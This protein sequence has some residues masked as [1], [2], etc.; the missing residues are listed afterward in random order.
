VGDAFHIIG[1]GEIKIWRNY[2]C[3]N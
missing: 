3:G 1:V 2:S